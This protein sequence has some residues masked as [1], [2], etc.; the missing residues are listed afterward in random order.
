VI[1]KRLNDCIENNDI[2]SDPQFG[3]LKVQSTD[4]IFLSYGTRISSSTA[5]T[6][7]H[8]RRMKCDDVTISRVL[9][10]YEIAVYCLSSGRKQ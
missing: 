3:L 5:G 1:N 4:A 9:L 6:P 7:P 2:L 10:L 8:V